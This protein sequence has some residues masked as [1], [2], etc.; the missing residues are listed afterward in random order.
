M[1]LR[2]GEQRHERALEEEQGFGHGARRPGGRAWFMWR[3][4]I[5]GL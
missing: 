1:D 3:Q 2:I 4:H 5:V